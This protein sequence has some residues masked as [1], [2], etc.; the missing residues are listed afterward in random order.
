MKLPST[1]HI[2]L[3]PRP[4]PVFLASNATT[5]TACTFQRSFQVR[6]VSF[7]LRLVLLI[8]FSVFLRISRMR[9]LQG[10]WITCQSLVLRFVATIKWFVLSALSSFVFVKFDSLHSFGYVSCTRPDGTCV[11]GVRRIFLRT[12]WCAAAVACWFL[13]LCGF[14]F[15]MRSLGIWIALAWVGAA[16]RRLIALLRWSGLGWRAFR[17]FTFGFIP[18]TLVSSWLLGVCKHS[19]GSFYLKNRQRSSVT[20]RL[21]SGKLSAQEAQLSC[22]IVRITSRELKWCAGPQETATRQARLLCA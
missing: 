13:E 5:S 3:H 15:G 8:T 22:L 10:Q 17:L 1:C 14:A 11:F 9:I 4:S 12:L 16:R 2:A 21:S 7:W 6:F 20:P 18:L 19:S